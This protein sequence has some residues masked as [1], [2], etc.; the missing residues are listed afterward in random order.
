[1][2]SHASSLSIFIAVMWQVV[3]LLFIYMLTAKFVDFIK[4]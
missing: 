4:I 1:M 3:F 2:R